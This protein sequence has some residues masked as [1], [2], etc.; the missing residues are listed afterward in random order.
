MAHSAFVLITWTEYEYIEATTS[1]NS[2]DHIDRARILRTTTLADSDRHEFDNVLDK[3]SATL[4]PMAKHT[5]FKIVE[6]LHV[7]SVIH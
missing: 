2:N 3:T 7:L 6:I 4:V 5:Q 1:N